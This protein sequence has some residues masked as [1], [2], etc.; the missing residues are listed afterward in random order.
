LRDY[1]HRH[2]RE[3]VSLLG[4]IC[5]ECSRE[6]TKEVEKAM[7]EKQDKAPKLGEERYICP[8]CLEEKLVYDSYKRLFI[9][10]N[11]NCGKKFALIEYRDGEEST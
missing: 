10:G 8:R 9:C 11:P 5:P 6:R 1:C 3:Y 4:S 2:Q 7:K